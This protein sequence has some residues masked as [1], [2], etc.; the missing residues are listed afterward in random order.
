MR[1]TV[2]A[3]LA[4]IGSIGAATAYEEWIGFYHGIDPIDGD[5]STLSITAKPDGTMH[6]VSTSD[7]ITFCDGGPGAFVAE[8]RIDGDTLLRENTKVRCRGSET[9]QDVRDSSYTYDRDNG[10]I[11]IITPGGGHPI[12]FHRF[13]G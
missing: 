9:L 6:I 5:V 11:Q 12:I 7:T 2:L 10:V 4:F 8:G 13:K 1:K 3:A